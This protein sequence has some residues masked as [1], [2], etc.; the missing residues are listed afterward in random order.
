MTKH[1]TDEND[2]VLWRAIYMSPVWR[3]EHPSEFLY[4]LAHEMTHAAG[5]NLRSDRHS[6]QWKSSTAW[7]F[8][9]TSCDSEER[10]AEVGANA[11]MQIFSVDISS[12]SFRETLGHETEDEVLEAKRRVHYMLS[13]LEGICRNEIILQHGGVSAALA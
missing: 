1:M 2:S 13:Y 8:G 11:L 10:I 12:W 4:V 9:T 3:F 6:G 7:T 5:V